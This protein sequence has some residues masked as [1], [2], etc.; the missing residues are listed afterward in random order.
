[1]PATAS[2]ALSGAIGPVTIA[3]VESE[4]VNETTLL[5]QPETQPDNTVV[6]RLIRDKI[7]DVLIV[8]NYQVGLKS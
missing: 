7:D 3:F 8:I 5:V 6:H 2:V 1:V 4:L